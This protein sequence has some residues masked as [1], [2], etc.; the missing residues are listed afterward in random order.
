MTHPGIRRRLTPFEDILFICRKCTKKLDGGFGADGGESLRRAL[1]PLLRD[2]GRRRST[3]IVE[4]KC[5]GLCPKHA[6]TAGTSRNPGVLL[7]IPRMTPAEAVLE[8]LDGHG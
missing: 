4:T 8:A 7:E 1:W 3:R 5:L 6:V 2:A